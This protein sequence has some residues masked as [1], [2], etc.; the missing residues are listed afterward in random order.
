[1]ANLR[2]LNESNQK[3]KKKRKRKNISSRKSSS[4]AVSHRGDSPHDAVYEMWIPSLEFS[5]R[6][7]I[8]GLFLEEDRDVGM[9]KS[10]VFTRM[11]EGLGGWFIALA[12]VVM[13]IIYVSVFSLN[14]LVYSAWAKAMAEGKDA[15]YLINGAVVATF[16]IS[17]ISTLRALLIYMKGV[18][19]SKTIHAKMVFQI[20]HAS[21]S[22]YFDRVPFGQLV[23]RFSSDIEIIDKRIF[24]L[25]GYVMVMFFFTLS[26]VFSVVVGA[27]NIL[28]LV[29][30][31]F[32]FFVGIWYRKR[33]MGAK[34]E[35]VRLYSITKSPICG[36]AESIIKGATVIRAIGRQKYSIKKMSHNI[37]EN[38]KN[39]LVSH[40]LDSWFLQRLALWSWIGV[41]MPSY[42]YVIYLFKFTEDKI[43]FGSFLLFIVSS[44]AL[45][46]GYQ[47]FVNLYS[48]LENTMISLERCKRFEEIESEPNYKTVEADRAIYQVPKNIKK[49]NK[50]DLEETEKEIL[51]ADGAIKISDLTARYPS[52]KEAALDK[53][54]ISIESGTKVGIVGRTGAG[55]SSF[56]K[57]FSM[58]LT[59]ESGDIKIDEKNISELDLKQLRSNIT[60]LSQKTSLFEGTLL[61][62]IDPYLEDQNKIQKIEQLLKRMGMENQDFKKKGLQMQLATDG[63][64]LSQGEQQTVSFIRAVH[65]RKKLVIFDEATSKI[66]LSTEELFKEATKEFFSDCTM[67]II[68]HRLQ[69]VMG[70]DKIAVFDKGQLV[71][72]DSPSNLRKVENSIFNRLCEKMEEEQD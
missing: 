4:V 52:R 5:E 20:M 14:I 9:V 72:Y 8:S 51:F 54:S 30:C 42:L 67:L 47:V 46:G 50:K 63:G 33:Y 18:R 55:K 16:I 68:A 70:C 71:N 53:I 60:V 48:E 12:L 28:L 36:W 24:P 31:F 49:F 10:T 1:M 11:I 56:I 29:P 64:N 6:S 21:I 61:E 69:T 34:R 26:N 39:G 19:A 45:A 65:K 17:I 22:E 35:M 41:V 66:D 3:K 38:T 23:N 57:L 32:F 43:D 7:S 13:T 59:P 40:A 44:T 27:S 58:I 25:I 15:L 2:K 37:E 62:S